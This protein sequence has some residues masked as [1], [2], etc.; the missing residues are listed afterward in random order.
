M[1]PLAEDD[2]WMI[3]VN[4]ARPIGDKWSIEGHAEYISERENSFGDV[5]AHILA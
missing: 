4:W 2:G 5:A 3:D 1:G